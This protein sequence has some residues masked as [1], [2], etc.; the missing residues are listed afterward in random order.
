MHH[1][2]VIR[3]QQLQE[4]TEPSSS[5]CHKLHVVK[6]RLVHL[7]RVCQ[8]CVNPQ[9]RVASSAKGFIND[10]KYHRF[11][12]KAI[13]LAKHMRAMQ[14]FLA[15]F[16]AIAKN[17]SPSVSPLCK[18]ILRL[19]VLPS[20]PVTEVDDAATSNGTGGDEYRQ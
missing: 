1:L 17:C 18:R 20:F 5:I 9:Y 16:F 7:P 3:L 10:L 13:F 4:Y 12:R 14:I 15:T 2:V 19:E 8:Y 6:Q 11:H